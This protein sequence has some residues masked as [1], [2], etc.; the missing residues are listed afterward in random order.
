MLKQI[1]TVT[2]LVLVAVLV[3]CGDQGTETTKTSMPALRT[4]K[5]LIIDVLDPQLYNEVHIKKAINIPF[6]DTRGEENKAYK[7][8]ALFQQEIRTQLG[9]AV[10]NSTKIIVYCSNEACTTS[11]VVADKLKQFGYNATPYKQGIAGW[12]LL[13]LYSNADRYPI[14]P[15]SDIRNKPFKKATYLNAFITSKPADV[16]AEKLAHFEKEA[17]PV[18]DALQLAA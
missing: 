6:L 11:D 7:S 5:A 14:E 2:L 13:H 9:S 15:A 3:S 12:V 18:V 1:S 16:T 10:D 8:A 4:L 17:Q